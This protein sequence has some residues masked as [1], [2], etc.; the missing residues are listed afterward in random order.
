MPRCPQVRAEL[1]AAKGDGERTRAAEARLMA[2]EATNIHLAKQIYKK[3]LLVKASTAKRQR[4]I[5]AIVLHRQHQK[6][7]FHAA[8]AIMEA[9]WHANA[10]NVVEG[11]YYSPLELP[12]DVARQGAPQLRHYFRRQ[13]RHDFGVHLARTCLPAPRHPARAG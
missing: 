11:A 8:G 6:R 4:A 13:L 9:T 12:P 3:K 7:H 1:E 5:A 10:D 2:A